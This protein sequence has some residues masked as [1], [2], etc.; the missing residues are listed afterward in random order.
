MIA[1]TIGVVVGTREGR[2]RPD[3]APRA[4]FVL[5]PAR[6][7]ARAAV[8]PGDAGVRRAKASSTSPCTT[9]R[10][11]SPCSSGTTR[12]PPQDVDRAGMRSTGEAA[13]RAT[14]CPDTPRSANRLAARPSAPGWSRFAAGRRERP[15]DRPGGCV[16]RWRPTLAGG[17]AR[18]ASGRVGPVLAVLAPSVT[19]VPG[20][21]QFAVCARG[22]GRA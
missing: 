22:G 6:G 20:A 17:D 11:I 12:P 9:G 10:A 1:I 2:H 14:R 21:H 13:S 3:D 7:I 4:R 8:V 5:V 19:L 16:V 15:A 18:G